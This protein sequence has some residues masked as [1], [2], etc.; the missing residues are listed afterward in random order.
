MQRCTIVAPSVPR[1]EDEQL[2]LLGDILFLLA[3][4]SSVS[5]AYIRH[6]GKRKIRLFSA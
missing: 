5:G 1:L 4:D 6:T 3:D 2:D